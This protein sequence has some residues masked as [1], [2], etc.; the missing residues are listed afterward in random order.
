[1]S[2][3]TDIRK[4]K[5]FTEQK[6]DYGYR[7]GLFIVFDVEMRKVVIEKCFENGGAVELSPAILDKLKA[8]GHG[9]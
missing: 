4:L 7:L 8:V 2:K 9:G 3:N 6:G 1:V 5:A